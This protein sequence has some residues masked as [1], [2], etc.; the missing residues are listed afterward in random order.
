MALLDKKYTPLLNLSFTSKT[1]EKCIAEQLVGSH[2]QQWPEWDNAV[3]IQKSQY[4]DCHLKVESHIL[5]NFEDGNV[6]CLVLP[7]IMA[8]CD[9]VNHKILLQRLQTR[10]GIKGI[11]LKWLESYPTECQQCVMIDRE[12][13]EPAL[14]KQGIPQGSI[15]GSILFSSYTTPLGNICHNHGIPC[16]MYAEN[17]QL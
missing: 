6:S 15:L 11:A 3:S 5:Q 8:T 16:M 7:D 9:T 10:Y 14:L 4:W 2:W 12:L 13:S 1:I 17:Q